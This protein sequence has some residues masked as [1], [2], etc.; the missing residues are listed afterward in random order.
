[1]FVIE[2]MSLE[3]SY[4]ALHIQCTVFA[5]CTKWFNNQNACFAWSFLCDYR[6]K[7]PDQSRS[8]SL[9]YFTVYFNIIFLY[10]NCCSG[11]LSF[12]F[13]VPNFECIFHLPCFVPLTWHPPWLDPRYSVFQNY[14]T[15]EHSWAWNVQSQKWAWKI[16]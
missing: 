5:L 1:M 16:I 13:S 15:P 3:V 12:R 4:H 2:W 7:E 10:M 11:F 6:S 9:Y 8:H 14:L